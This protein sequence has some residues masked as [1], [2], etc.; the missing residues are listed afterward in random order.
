M[1]KTFSPVY[2]LALLAVIL[3]SCAIPQPVIRMDP[4]AEE[5]R[6][7]Y[8]VAF[9][10]I[11]SQKY[12]VR[13]A[14]VDHDREM[15]FFDVIVYNHSN[16]DILISPEKLYLKT[17]HGGRRY[18]LNPESNILSMDLRQSQKEA[19]AKNMAVAA[20]IAAVGTAVAIALTDDGVDDNGALQVIDGAQIGLDL[21]IG[22]SG[23]AYASLG[24]TYYAPPP[25]P[26]EGLPSRELRSFW[27]DYTLRRTTVAPGESVRGIVVIRR[28]DELA[29]LEL[30]IP[31]GEE[32]YSFIFKQRL[33][34]P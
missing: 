29:E 23:L 27:T 20:G 34:K 8:G 22:L 19:D 9:G 6:W 31:V 15:L 21:Y 14:Y 2:F 26:D 25:P 16:E 32:D 24:E 10:R 17:A 12:D 3:N 18:A 11:Q 30:V 7:D 13:A 28:M 33:I 1:M 5:I 4:L